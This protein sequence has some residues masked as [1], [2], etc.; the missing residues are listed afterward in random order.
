MYRYEVDKG[1]GRWLLLNEKGAILHSTPSTELSFAYDIE[2]GV[3]HKHGSTPMVNSWVKTAQAKLNGAGASEMANGLRVLTVNSYPVIGDPKPG[4]Q[5]MSVEDANACTTTSG[6][7][8]R[9]I[10]KLDAIDVDAIELTALDEA[11]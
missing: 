3:L 4:V 6:Y 8:L 5:Y 10:A 9:V 2:F 1:D 11:P 7:I